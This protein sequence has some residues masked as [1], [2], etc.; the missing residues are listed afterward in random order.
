MCKYTDRKIELFLSFPS[1]HTLLGLDTD[2]QVS[3]FSSYGKSETGP[4]GRTLRAQLKR[5]TQRSTTH[6]S[7]GVVD[8]PD[9]LAIEIVTISTNLLD[10][11]IWYLL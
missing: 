1:H 5:H 8:E 6:Q 9:Q 11:M 4:L 10:Y 7:H 2:K 3:D